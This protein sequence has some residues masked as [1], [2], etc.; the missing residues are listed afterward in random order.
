MLKMPSVLGQLSLPPQPGNTRFR[1]PWSCGWAEG[2]EGTL[3]TFNGSVD[4]DDTAHGGGS[5]ATPGDPVE[6]TALLAEKAMGSQAGLA[7]GAPRPAARRHPCVPALGHG[8]AGHPSVLV[9]GSGLATSS[10][11]RGCP[12]AKGGHGIVQQHM[13]RLRHHSLLAARCQGQMVWVL[14]AGRM[15]PGCSDTAWSDKEHCVLLSNLVPTHHPPHSIPRAKLL[16]GI[17][18]PSWGLP[19]TG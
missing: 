3:R 4:E 7:A 18:V 19:S 15:G 14:G 11:G 16:Q 5:A 12:P 13:P 8:G 9:S 2:C 10:Q 17:W 1:P 6:Q